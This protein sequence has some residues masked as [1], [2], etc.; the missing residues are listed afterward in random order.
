M[1]Q[2]SGCACGSALQGPRH[3]LRS[4][5][6]CGNVAVNRQQHSYNYPESGKDWSVSDIVHL[7]HSSASPS[8]HSNQPRSSEILIN[9]CTTSALVKYQEILMHV[10]AHS[11]W[12]RTQVS[13]NLL[14][15]KKAH[16]HYVNIHREQQNL[17]CS[18]DNSFRVG[19]VVVELRIGPKLSPELGPNIGP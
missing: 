15:I 13:G 17:C 1:Q 18:L 8:A 19:I 5:V 7:L 9:V 12:D 6:G 2:E 10:Y 11:A 16:L 3:L 4:I 14:S